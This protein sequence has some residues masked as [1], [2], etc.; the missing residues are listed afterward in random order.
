[1]LGSVRRQEWR[2]PF[3]SALIV[4]RAAQTKA[5][6]AESTLNVAAVKL[7]R[8]VAHNLLG[9]HARCDGLN[10]ERVTMIRQA[11]IVIN[12]WRRQYNHKRPHLL[13]LR[14]T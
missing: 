6:P 11:K 7:L 14:P 5:S 8:Q 2:G 3:S 10:S 12:C 1:M 9:L 13:R 4:F